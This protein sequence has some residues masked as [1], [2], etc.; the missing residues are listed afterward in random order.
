M[1]DLVCRWRVTG[2]FRGQSKSDCGWEAGS[3]DFDTY[4]F[5]PSCGKP[6]RY[7]QSGIEGYF[8]KLDK[9]T[10]PEFAQLLDNHFDELT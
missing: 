7:A 10:P 9:P 8:S 6:V 5:C 2:P 4:K 3:A 1:S